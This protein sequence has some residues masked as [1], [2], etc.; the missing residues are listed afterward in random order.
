MDVYS[1]VQP[2]HLIAFHLKFQAKY[3]SKDTLETHLQQSNE[4]R[5]RGEFDL[6]STPLTSSTNHA[7]YALPFPYN[8]RGCLLQFTQGN[9]KVML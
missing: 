1:S 2:K 7:K 3:F 9:K 6:L 5:K 8:P 4:L